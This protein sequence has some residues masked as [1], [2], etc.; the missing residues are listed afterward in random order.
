MKKLLLSFTAITAIGAGSA[1]A[2]DMPVKAIYKAPPVYAFS[3]TGCYIG[4]NAG[5]LW[6]RKDY[7]VA[8][9]L[10]AIPIGVAAIPAAPIGTNLGSHD[11]NSWVGG[12]QAGCNY[13]FGNW[14]VGIQGDYDWTDATGTHSDLYFL[15]VTDRSRARSLGSVTGRVGYAW[16]RFL[17]YVKG[18]G[19]WERDNYDS[20][21]TAAPAT[22]VTTASETR[23]GWT[24][25]I[26]GEYAFTNWLTGFVEYDYYD[27]GTRT[28]A[29]VS[30]T[31]GVTIVN[32]DLRERKS[33]VKVGLNF[34]FGD[35]SPVVA[36]Y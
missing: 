18:G 36:R 6:Q 31:T 22:I 29:F 3:W 12:V 7:T 28:N 27:F 20:Y 30:P 9:P 24:V 34:K 1:L 35:W 5:G 16:D 26:G 23:G 13:Q 32:V 2:A 33:V 10:G 25:G 17:G 8:A 4:G 15:T 21:L 19:A 14:V 11:A